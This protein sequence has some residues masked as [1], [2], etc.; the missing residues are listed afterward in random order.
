MSS[1]VVKLIRS[2][3]LIVAVAGLLML[4]WVPSRPWVKLSLK[5]PVI[6]STFEAWVSG[7]EILQVAD[8]LAGIGS[9]IN[10]TAQQTLNLGIADVS[11]LDV[12]Q[13]TLDST[14]RAQL[15]DAITLGTSLAP[16]VSVARLAILILPIT[17][18]LFAILIIRSPPLISQRAKAA[19]LFSISL[20]ASFALL[21]VIVFIDSTISKLPTRDSVADV[22]GN[23]GLIPAVIAGFMA[24]G[25]S[26]LHLVS[27]GMSIHL[28]ESGMTWQ[29]EPESPGMRSQRAQY[30]PGVAEKPAVVEVEKLP[31]EAWAPKR[32]DILIKNPTPGTKI[33]WK[34]NKEIA[35]TAQYCRHC[36]SRQGIATD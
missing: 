27:R 4:L 24:V 21:A 23:G 9:A 18:L 8:G 13:L 22:S 11:L 6:G 29:S 36:G 16:F 14:T 5:A 15:M 1:S 28:R 35:A 31:D 7:Y 17:G 2:T 25:G 26:A 34:C 32:P 30:P 19:M 3:G 20:L 12:V 33:C 10:R